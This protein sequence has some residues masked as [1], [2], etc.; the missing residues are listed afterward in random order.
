MKYKIV[1]PDV[2]NVTF[3][4]LDLKIFEQ[5]GDVVMNPTSKT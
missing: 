3:G 1:L 5:F 4:D 2:K